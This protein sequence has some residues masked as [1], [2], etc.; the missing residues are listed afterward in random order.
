MGMARDEQLARAIAQVHGLRVRSMR[1]IPGRGAVNHVFI[2]RSPGAD[3]VIRFA[4]D[5]LRQNDFVAEAWCLARANDVGIPSPSV[6]GV[7]RMAI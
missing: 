3:S 5:P 2:V 4:I 6:V 1:A 7:S